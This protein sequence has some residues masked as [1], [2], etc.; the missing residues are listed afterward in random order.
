M[1]RKMVQEKSLKYMYWGSWRSSN[2]ES[3]Q[4]DKDG[5]IGRK[6]CIYKYYI[7]CNLGERSE[8]SETR[9]ITSTSGING[10]VTFLEW[11]MILIIVCK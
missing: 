2:D 6:K 11:V 8:L 9:E 10:S 4:F 1:L 7:V 3:S 5:L